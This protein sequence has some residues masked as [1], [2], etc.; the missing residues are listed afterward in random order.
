MKKIYSTPMIGME[1]VE[2]MFLMS[3]GSGAPA[4]TPTPPPTLN[5]GGNASELGENPVAF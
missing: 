3:S 4:P 2:S 5:V 1:Q